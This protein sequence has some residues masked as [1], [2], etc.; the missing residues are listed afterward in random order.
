MDVL[1]DF[2]NNKFDLKVTGGQVQL[3]A[4]LQTA[5]YISLFTD[6][7][8]NEDDPLPDTDNRRGFWSD[9]VSPL[10]DGVLIGSRLWLLYREKQTAETANRARLYTEEALQWLI[11]LEIVKK[12]SVSA[13]WV[14][15]GVLGLGISLEKPDAKEKYYYEYVWQ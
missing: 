14:K 4:D 8:A 13:E 7:L 15:Q 11:D 10:L 1:I 3:G 9:S 2:K 5:V 6:R 12:L